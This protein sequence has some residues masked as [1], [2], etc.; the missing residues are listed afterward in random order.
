VTALTNHLSAVTAT[1]RAALGNRRLRRLQTAL[2]LAGTSGPVYTVALLLYAYEQGGAAE[3]GVVSLVVM[4][5]AGVLALV[6]APVADRLRRDRVLF[7]AACGR[8]LILAA[9]TCFVVIDAYPPLVYALAALAS[10]ASRLYFPAHAASLPQVARDDDE[11]AA[12]NALGS[13]IDS[14][15]TLAGPALAAALLPFG[16]AFGFAAGTV[17]SLAAAVVVSGAGEVRAEPV[18]RKG[19]IEELLAGIRIVGS[20]SGVRVGVALFAAQVL[21]LGALGVLVVELALGVLDLGPGGVGLLEGASGIGGVLG[22]VLALRAT[23]VLGNGAAMR[24]GSLLFG[25]A[26]AGVALAPATPAVLVLL[27][28]VGAGVVLIDVPG[29]TVIQRRAP[30]E[31]LGRVFGALE[32][33]L[34]AASGVGSLLGGLLVTTVGVQTALLVVGALVPAVAAA[35]WRS[36]VRLDED[37]PA[38][39]PSRASVQ[40]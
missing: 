35:C 2:L 25:L 17:A 39:V 26:I 32:G 14:G 8:G 33:I 16:A 27:G 11:L 29:Y 23:Q 6:L 18:A 28:L 36:F 20:E 31:A 5:P 13:T 22:G 19:R 38:F 7:A 40:L 37:V 15:A 1:L 9:A 30:V 34:V 24:L 4:L 10:I 21:V 3:A 12:A